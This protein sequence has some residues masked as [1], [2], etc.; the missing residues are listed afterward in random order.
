MSMVGLFVIQVFFI[1][2]NSLSLSE[3]SSNI[4]QKG[5]LYSPLLPMRC[6]TPTC[7]CDVDDLNRKRVT[8][9]NG[10]LGRIPL[11]KMDKDIQV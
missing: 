2:I 4:H 10:N 8:C 6:P 3:S 1:L 11:D 9:A 5:L 7:E